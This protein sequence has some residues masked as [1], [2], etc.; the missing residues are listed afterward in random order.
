MFKKKQKKGGVYCKKTGLLKEWIAPIKKGP[1]PIPSQ[2]SGTTM[3]PP[4]P[5]PP[6][7]VKE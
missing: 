3:Q 6:R 7:I 2:Q 5:P 4:I 1:K